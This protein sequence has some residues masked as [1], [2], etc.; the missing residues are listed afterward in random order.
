MQ[1]SLHGLKFGWGGQQPL[2]KPEAFVLPASTRM[3]NSFAKQV[4]A[5]LERH[6]D[7]DP[8]FVV[9]TDLP[10][11]RTLFSERLNNLLYRT[12]STFDHWY[13]KVDY[14]LRPERYIELMGGGLPSP[15]LDRLYQ[16]NSNEVEGSAFRKLLNRV[17]RQQGLHKLKQLPQREK[18]QTGAEKVLTITEVTHWPELLPMQSLQKGTFAE[19]LGFRFSP[20][21]PKDGDGYL[22]IADVGQFCKD[23]GLE[24]A[25][26]YQEETFQG[27]PMGK[28]MRKD[29]QQ[30]ILERYTITLKPELAHGKEIG[31]LL[32]TNNSGL[33]YRFSESSAKEF[34]RTGKRPF[35]FFSVS[36]HVLQQQE[37]SPQALE[38]WRKSGKLIELPTDKP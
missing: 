36:N 14:K 11:K 24:E 4:L 31:I 5:R 29:Y 7:Q 3:T 35:D 23:K 22:H 2:P 32:N 1:V 9:V 21:F 25:D 27:I 6:D 19:T 33:Y 15:L 30:E 37:L 10:S 34:R 16:R 18:E 38:H 26:L 20:L 12:A 17:A 13:R 28:R 8:G